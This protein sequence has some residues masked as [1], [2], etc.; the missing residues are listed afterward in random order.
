MNLYIDFDGVILDTITPSYNKMQEIGIDSKNAEKVIEY[1]EN[2]DWKEFIKESPEIND[3]LECIK[4]I[5]ESNKYNVSILTHVTSLNE[6]LAKIHFIRKTIKEITIIPVPKKISK[7]KM[8]NVNNSILIDDYAGNLKEWEEE[9]GIAVKFSTKLNGK[10]YRVIDK[11]DQ[12]L[13]LEF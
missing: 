13:E 6:A 5:F 2:V 1:Y 8:V 3:G 4:K 12:I 9:G 11:L 10:G 7:T